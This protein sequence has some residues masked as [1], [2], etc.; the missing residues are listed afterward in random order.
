MAQ[1]TRSLLVSNLSQQNQIYF[2]QAF[3]ITFINKCHTF[4]GQDLNNQSLLLPIVINEII[5]NIIKRYENV[6]EIKGILAESEL[7]IF[8][9]VY[10]SLAF[11][12]R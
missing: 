1:Q 9:F 3:L 2:L 12:Q 6:S 4:Y 7:Q 10:A 11:F 8:L 5:V